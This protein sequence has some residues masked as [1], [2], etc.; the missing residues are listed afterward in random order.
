MT[1]IGLLVL[2][3]PGGAALWAT[4]QANT[5]MEEQA[6][7][8]QST[9][10]DTAASELAN[11]VARAKT[12]VR[13]AA[14]RDALR[15][16][17]SAGDREA[18]ARLLA[19]TRSATPLLRSI[20]LL[21]RSPLRPPVRVPPG[22]PVAPGATLAW[23]APAVLPA[24]PVGDDAVMV[25]REPVMA[26]DGRAMATVVA[27]ISLAASAPVVRTLR[28]GRTG[29]ALVVDD[30]GLVLLAG[31]PEQIG[32]TWALGAV[33][34]A[35][36]RS[37]AGRFTF[38]SPV[39]GRRE[40]ATV[41]QVAGRP[42]RLVVL[43]SEAEFIA[44]VRRLNRLVAGG[45]GIAAGLLALLAAAAGRN[46][47]V[48]ER[49]LRA[50]AQVIEAAADA[51]VVCG[52]DGRVEAWNQGA[53]QLYGWPADEAVGQPLDELVRRPDG[54][55]ATAGPPAGEVASWRAELTHLR[56]DG[57]QVTVLRR[58][59]VAADE[60]G[61]PAALLV[62]DTDVTASREAEKVSA[63]LASVV[64]GSDDAILSTTLD[65]LV[66]HWN[67][68]AERIYGWPA[69]EIT[70]R[71]LTELVAPGGAGQLALAAVMAGLRAGRGLRGAQTEHRRADGTPVPVSLTVSPVRDR[72]GRLVGAS[73]I[74]RDERDR[75]R[76]EAE[77]RRQRDLYERLLGGL[78]EL[79]EGVAVIERDRLVFVNDCFCQL[80]GYE[81]D[82]LLALDSVHELNGVDGEQSPFGVDGHGPTTRV[83]SR[84][85]RR[86]G[87]LVPVE[88]AMARLPSGPGL[89]AQRIAVVRDVSIRLA[90]E[91]AL[92]ERARALQAANAEL[93]EVNQL[94]TDLVAMLSHDVG[95]PLSTII[96]WS[97]VLADDWDALDDERR[98]AYVA[99]VHAG[100]ARI[101]DL[102]GAVLTM[103]RLEAGAIQAER[104][105][106]PVADAIR[107]AAEAAGDAVPDVRVGAADGLAALADP[108][109]LQQILVNLLTNAAKYGRPPFAIEAAEA[110]PGRVR[111]TVT[112]QGEGVPQEFVPHLFERFS[113]AASGA[114]LEARG[115]GLG[116]FI[117]RRL[118]EANSGRAT[119]EPNRPTGSCFVIELERTD[120]P[121][122]A[123][124]G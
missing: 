28:L 22:P 69:A 9:A 97:E 18:V 47:A 10:A 117:V 106:V 36:G 88:L 96:G 66:T 57:T 67:A 116:L 17:V 41:A 101:G 49:R 73:M 13:S 20:A 64:A 12:Q 95:Q 94:K 4:M 114:A 33:G 30:R 78:S 61:R 3:L 72:D 19:G 104:R 82:E 59:S 8:A 11:G 115:T 38:A 120:A 113:R 37:S 102:V 51:I 107:Q 14:A 123:R 91:V 52:L 27:E 85:R 98:R 62:I 105:P 75:Q 46:L 42:W 74:V 44:P 108:G 93:R 35:P 25:V 103:A 122:P 89:R 24:H 81:A 48:H 60:R 68:A 34:G 21:D 77:L 5:V 43:Q 112:D 50:Q 124:A 100:A 92:A 71:S 26:P 76:L 1:V 40:A 29:R 56:R 119:Y 86:T 70:G 121:V 84:L 54:R 65:G 87:D 39:T 6:A 55:D 31:G 63:H 32:Q 79:G 53:E 118:A 111:V 58:Q 80:T 7:S 16:A 45:L 15:Q 2:L 109:H 83:E 99:K 90:Y 23:P 110:G